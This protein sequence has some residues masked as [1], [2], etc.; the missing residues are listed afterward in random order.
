MPPRGAED[1]N[2]DLEV[3]FWSTS[4]G[5]DPSRHTVAHD[6]EIRSEVNSKKKRGCTGTLIEFPPEI[7]DIPDRTLNPAFLNILRHT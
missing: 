4:F 6:G 5:N 1:W 7:Y 2:A 3:R